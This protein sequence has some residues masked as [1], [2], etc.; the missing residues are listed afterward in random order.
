M[1]YILLFPSQIDNN[2]QDN[3]EAQKSAKCHTGNERQVG[4]NIF[5]FMYK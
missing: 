5:H 1:E 3:E 2:L 4:M